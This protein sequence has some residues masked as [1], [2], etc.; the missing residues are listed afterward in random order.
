MNPRSEKLR[1]RAVDLGLIQDD[2]PMTELELE[3][4][5][6]EFSEDEICDTLEELLDDA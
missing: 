6:G 2:G 1:Q 4:S 5:R 3:R